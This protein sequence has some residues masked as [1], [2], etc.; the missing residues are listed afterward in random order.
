MQL[1]NYNVIFTQYALWPEN[2]SELL[3]KFFDSEALEHTLACDCLNSSMPTF[4]TKEPTSDYDRMVGVNVLYE[5]LRSLDSDFDTGIFEDR[6]EPDVFKAKS[7][8]S[9]MTTFS[10]FI[11]GN[12]KATFYAEMKRLHGMTEA[13]SPIGKMTAMVDGVLARRDRMLKDLYEIYQNEKA[14]RR[15]IIAGAMANILKNERSTYID[16]K[17]NLELYDAFKAL[18]KELNKIV[19]EKNGMNVSVETIEACDR[20]LLELGVPGDSIIKQAWT[21]KYTRK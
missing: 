1:K 10:G 6:F 4:N 11:K 7:Q 5:Y 17:F 19:S 18:R 16:E 13:D 21:D 2:N 14:N 3:K 9:M 8:F 12:P 20:K 15:G